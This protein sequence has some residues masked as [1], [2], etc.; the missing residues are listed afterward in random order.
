MPILQEIKNKYSSIQVQ[1]YNSLSRQIEELKILEEGKLS[2]YTCGPTVYDSSH[3]GHARSMLVWDIFVRYL[4]AYGLDVKWARNIT[5][6]DDKII[7]RAS[8][9]NLT[10]DVLARREIFKFW[11]DMNAL[12]ISTPDIE[13]RATE[14]LQ[15]IFDFIQQLIDKGYAYQA[16]NNDVYFRVHKFANYGQLKN[17][18]DEQTLG[19]SRIDSN[20]CKENQEDFALWKAFDESEYAFDSPFGWGRPGW[21][22]EC[23]AMIKKHFGETID[24]HGGGEDLLFPHH[25]N[26]IAQSESLHD[27]KKFANYWVHNAMILINGRKMSKSENNFI[28]I[29]EALK[30][31]TGNAIRLF[32]ITTHYRQA[33]NFT[34]EALQSAQ[35]SINKITKLLQEY[36]ISSKSLQNINQQEVNEELLLEFMK[37]MANNMNTSQALAVVFE[38]VSFVNK[39]ENT[40][41]NLNTLIYCLSVLGFDLDEQENNNLDISKFNSIFN[42][43]LEMRQDARQNKDFA[44]S[45]KIRDAF[46]EASITIKDT[47]EGSSLEY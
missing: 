10:P 27:N 14:S 26:E 19:Q 9:L 39:K 40:E 24:I 4:R 44:T 5:D 1:I 33:L 46:A 18:Q 2:I 28:T 22:I 16:S 8:E 36:K 30:Q 31:Y 21:H 32:T 6:I 43:L 7:K 47:R 15:A 3:I 17:I 23:S 12:N 35:N 11:R 20:S 37:A 41:I 38:L 45:D 42:L 13:P 25:E 34:E 29:Q